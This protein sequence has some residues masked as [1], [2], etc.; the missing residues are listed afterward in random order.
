MGRKCNTI[1]REYGSRQKNIWFYRLLDNL[2][3]DFRMPLELS[4]TSRSETSPSRRWF[5]LKP[6][7]GRGKVELLHQVK[8]VSRLLF[9]IRLIGTRQWTRVT[10]SIFFFFRDRLVFYVEKR[11]MNPRIF[12]RTLFIKYLRKIDSEEACTLRRIPWTFIGI[13]IRL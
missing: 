11:T 10:I 1:P 9:S 13:I 5:M 6:P 12:L 8:V 7:Q 3:A 2:K 4:W